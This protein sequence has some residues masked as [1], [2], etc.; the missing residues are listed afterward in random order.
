MKTCLEAGTLQSYLDGELSPNAMQSVAAHLASC[1]ACA[2]LAREAEAELALFMEAMAPAA[3]LP[4]SVPT[5]RLRERLD[6][7]LAAEATGQHDKRPAA[8]RGESGWREWLAGLAAFLTPAPGRAVA[9][10]SLLVAV[11]LSALFVSQQ[12]APGE[13]KQSEV[14]VV[15]V[16]SGADDVPL[17]NGVAPVAAVN[18]ATTPTPPASSTGPSKAA[19]R[20]RDNRDAVNQLAS[21]S[22]RPRPSGGVTQATRGGEVASATGRPVLLP[23]E[24]TYLS[25]IASLTSTIESRTPQAMPP[26]LRVEY[27]RNLALVDQA[28]LSTRVAARRNPQDT[29]AQDFLRSAYQNKV[30][31]L[32]AVA[33]QSQLATIKD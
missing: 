2:A 14:A 27:E 32:S 23:G 7:A 21:Y 17:T 24:K 28:I 6:A 11:L 25:A 29:D 5:A 12:F 15:P 26:S 4:A 22:S 18:S 16:S 3:L 33:E 19:P 8:A 30:E 20:K 10:A 31:L 9:F 1:R 13:I